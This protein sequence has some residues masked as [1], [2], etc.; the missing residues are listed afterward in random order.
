MARCI[1]MVQIGTEDDEYQGQPK[2]LHR[3]RITWELPTETK[4]FK[5]E[6]GE[7]PYLISKDYTLS[8]HAKA[9]LR[10]HLESWRGKP[11]TDEEAN[12][13]DITKLLGVACMLNV[14][15]VP[16]AKGNLKARLSSVAAMPKGVKCPPQIMPQVVLCYP[17]PGEAYD[18]KTYEALPEWL[19]TRISATPEFKAMKEPQV[20]VVSGGNDAPAQEEDDDKLP[21]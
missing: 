1:S 9:T 8:M 14:I 11:Y 10:H 12:A 17:G 15:H 13:V 3:V 5:E 21:F 2:K 16:D 7:Q 4:V 18:W 20:T 6:N 19:R